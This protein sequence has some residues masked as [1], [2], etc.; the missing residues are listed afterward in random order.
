M[1][2]VG[3]SQTTKL[4]ILE[5]SPWFIILASAVPVAALIILVAV[6]FFLFVPDGTFD[7]GNLYADCGGEGY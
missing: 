6:F 7:C 2:I 1:P 3:L 5:V 4:L